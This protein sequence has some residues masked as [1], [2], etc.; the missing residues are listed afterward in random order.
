LL[1]VCFISLTSIVST[2]TQ[3]DK[4][5]SDQELRLAELSS[6][7]DNSRFKAQAIEMNLYTVDAAIA[8]IKSAMQSGVSW[9]ELTELVKMQKEVSLVS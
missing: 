2:L 3:V 5:K 6:A 7:I 9:D 8:V 4:L 1:H